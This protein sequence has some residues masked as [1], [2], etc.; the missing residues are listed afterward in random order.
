M[1]F[2]TEIECLAAAFL[3]NAI[4]NSALNDTSCRSPTKLKNSRRADSMGSPSA[5]SM[6]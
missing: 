5:S 2:V 4:S 3:R 1:G 6:A